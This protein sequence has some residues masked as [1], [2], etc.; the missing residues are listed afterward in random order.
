MFRGSDAAG[1]ACDEDEDTNA[2][3]YVGFGLSDLFNL[4]LIHVSP[5]S[6]KKTHSRGRESSPRTETEAKSTGPLLHLEITTCKGGHFYEAFCLD[7]RILSA[8]SLSPRERPSFS[9]VQLTLTM[10]IPNGKGP[11]GTSD[12]DHVSNL[13]NSI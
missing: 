12:T 7:A 5:S 3:V 6:E 1:N 10:L 9:V 8:A 13:E 4:Q 11:M 2:G